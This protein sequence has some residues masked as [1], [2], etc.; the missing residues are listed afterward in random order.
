MAEGDWALTFDNTEGYYR[1]LIYL[2]YGVIILDTELS[3]KR[4]ISEIDPATK[5][6]KP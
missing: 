5:L 2:T 1:D 6:E 4:R 3:W